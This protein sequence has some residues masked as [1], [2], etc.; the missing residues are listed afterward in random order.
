MTE[1]YNV[2]ITDG[3]RLSNNDHKVDMTLGDLMKERGYNWLRGSIRVNCC[4]MPDNAMFDTLEMIQHD[5]LKAAGK[6]YTTYMK[7]H[8]KTPDNDPTKKREKPV[9]RQPAERKETADVR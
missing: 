5:T 2:F 1:T 8:C 9:R 7:I 6:P 3:N 4:K